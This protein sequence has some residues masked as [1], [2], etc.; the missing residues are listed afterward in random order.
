MTHLVASKR[1]ATNF[2]N[3]GFVF[4]WVLTGLLFSTS[5]A[6][7]P[8]RFEFSLNGL[9]F[10]LDARSGSLLKI[11]SPQFGTFLETTPERAGI[12]DL[13]YPVAQFQPLRLGA[14]FSENV[15]IKAEARQVTL[16]WESLGASRDLA[17]S[18]KVAVSVR[19]AA[20]PAASR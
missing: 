17:L 19:F 4:F 15:K 11:S 12:I 16:E 8:D 6:A 2:K 20:A 3:R 18:G 1:R 13:A 5:R 7:E 14:R 9:T 10:V